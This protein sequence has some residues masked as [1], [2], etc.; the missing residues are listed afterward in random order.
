MKIYSAEL[1]K[2]RGLLYSNGFYDK[3]IETMN[4]LIVRHICARN[5]LVIVDAGCGEGT[6]L[7]RL[8]NQMGGKKIG[9]DISKDAILQASRSSKEILWMVADLVN[10]PIN[11]NSV[12]VLFNIFSPANYQSFARIL[13]KNGV[14]IKV[15]PGTDYL[16]EIREVSE[17]LINKQRDNEEQVVNYLSRYM[18]II[19]K[20]KIYYKVNVNL[21]QLQAWIKM[22]PM[23][24]NVMVDKKML[25]NIKQV[26]RQNR[27]CNI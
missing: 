16:R 22:T 10:I 27:V 20:K 17:T 19:E 15:I 1:F 13:K 8:C 21:E 23:M 9:F 3:I 2:N 26:R 18:K 7:T 25:L 24:A 5:N 6:F 12:D 14:L 4:L 11:D